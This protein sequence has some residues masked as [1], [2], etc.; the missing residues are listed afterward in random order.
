MVYTEILSG[1]WIGNIDMMYNKQF[2]QDN[3]IQIIINCTTNYQCKDT[4][5]TNIRIPLVEDLYANINTLR[6][7][8]GKILSYI[9]TELENNN[10]LI[11]CYDGQTLSPFII[12]LYLLTYGDISKDQVKQI[13]RSKNT[14]L[15]MDFDLQLLDL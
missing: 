5:I 10:I 12:S 11:C 14:E 9:K 1:L 6:T 8:K 13:C 15:S 7:N 4:T 3:N 2:I